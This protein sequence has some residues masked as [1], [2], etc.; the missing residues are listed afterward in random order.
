MIYL[1]LHV[2]VDTYW[3]WRGSHTRRVAHSHFLSFAF[4]L[5]CRE[6]SLFRHAMSHNAHMH[7]CSVFA[8][9]ASEGIEPLVPD[10]CNRYTPKTVTEDAAPPP[11][12][13]AQAP[14]RKQSAFDFDEVSA[15]RR[16]VTITTEVSGMNVVVQ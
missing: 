4:S 7:V 3:D 14:I 6:Y 1:V 16:I 11:L 12:P 8:R 5:C 15:P 13:Q 9:M 2:L 10:W